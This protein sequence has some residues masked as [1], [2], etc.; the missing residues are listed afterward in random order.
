MSKIQLNIA[1]TSKFKTVRIQ[2]SFLGQPSKKDMAARAV[3]INMMKQQSKDYPSKAALLN[4]LHERYNMRLSVLPSKIGRVQMLSFTVDFIHSD[5]TLEANDMFIDAIEVLESI[6]KRPKLSKKLFLQEKRILEEYFASIY[7]DKSHYAV[8]AMLKHMYDDPF[9][10]M[11]GL[12]D[13]EDV[14]NLTYENILDV[15]QSLFAD[16][17]VCTVHG[18]VDEKRVRKVLNER[19]QQADTE[20]QEYQYTLTH[21]L[22]K[23]RNMVTEKQKIK[24]TNLVIGV[25]MPVYFDESDYFKTRFFNVILGGHSESILFKEIRE[26][27]NMAYYISSSYNPYLGLMIIQTGIDGKNTA[28]V[29]KTIEEILEKL[30]RG[31]LSDAIFTQSKNQLKNALIQSQDSQARMTSQKTLQ[32]IFGLSFSLEDR[33]EELQKISKEDMANIA[34]KMTISTIFELTG[35]TNE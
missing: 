6:I 7:A 11:D 31:I 1:Q 17:I 21:K 24:Q 33:L 32:S 13:L 12:G 29:I 23:E 18:Q 35:E 25:E 27:R 2:L 15:Y 26:K 9:Y 3:L 10:Y 22:S 8:H 30:Q 19:F 16:Q 5:Y 34:K 28:K 20:D 14:K 4:H